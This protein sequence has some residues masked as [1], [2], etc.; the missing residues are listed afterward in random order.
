[1]EN[2]NCLLC[3][4]EFKPTHKTTRFCS[5]SCAQRINRNNKTGYMDREK[6]AKCH[7]IIGMLGSMSGKLVGL[8]KNK[9]STLR[10]K[11]GLK[12]FTSREAS[13]IANALNGKQAKWMS[14]S[15]ED[16]WKG[17]VD[18]YWTLCNSI[19]IEKMFNTK[20]RGMSDQMIRY[21]GDLE[22]RREQ[23]RKSAKKRY[24]KANKNSLFILKI[25]LRNHISR[26][27]R[28]SKTG[29][30][31]RTIEYLGCDIN[32]ARSHIQRCFKKGMTWDNHGIVWEIDHVIPMSHFDLSREDQRMRVNHFTNLKPEFKRYNREKGSRMIGEHQIALL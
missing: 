13:I 27:C 15:W 9:I 7:A 18:N 3:G 23:S 32:H 11:N 12:T 1:M 4:K 28:K 6:C 31:R 25:K 24:G 17:V 21:Y 30:T 16:E 5:L 20:M 26:V 10:K 8:S 2:R 14:E 29:K 19:T 22:K